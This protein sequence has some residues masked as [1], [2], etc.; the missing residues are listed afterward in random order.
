MSNFSDLCKRTVDPKLVINFLKQSDSQNISNGKL[1]EYLELTFL[2]DVTGSMGPYIEMAKNKI[3][4]MIESLEM[5]LTL[6]LMKD[7][8]KIDFNVVT[9]VCLVCY[10]D[11]GDDN[12]FQYLQQT[13]DI[14]EVYN[15]LASIKVSGGGDLPEDILGA[16][17]VMLNNLSQ[18]NSSKNTT[19]IVILIADSP[20]H[21][22]FMNGGHDDRHINANDEE[23]WKTCLQ[24]L[25]KHKMEFICVQLTENMSQM[26]N[27]FK[28][29]YDDDINMVGVVKITGGDTEKVAEELTSC[30]SKYCVA[31]I[32]KR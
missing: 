29:I 30:I 24:T 12:H 27:F 3:K 5:V 2:L 14:D 4:S 10:R 8:G 18:N 1:V 16:F 25:K 26:V 20:G 21:G 15:A 11:F 13:K 9:K 19:K 17:V 31:S 23:D 7:R 6:K 28:N 22:K 32:D